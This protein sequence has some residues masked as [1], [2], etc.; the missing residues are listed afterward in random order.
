MAD[1]VTFGETM[2]RLS[3]PDHRRLEQTNLLDVNIGGAEWNVAVDLSRLGISTAWVSRLTDNALGWMIRNKAREQGVDISHIAWTKDDRIGIYFVEFGATP[4]PSSV[5]YDR[6]HS[7]ISQVKPGEINW[8]EVLK[9]AKW[10]H[11]S[12]I[13]PA[14][15][16]GA[17]Q[18]TTEALQIA[19]KAGCKVSYDLNYRGRLWTE[20]EA[21]KCQEPLMEHVDVL[22]STEE[23]TRKVLGIT[24]KDYREVAQK[25][26][27]NFNFEVVC[28]TLREDVSVLRNRWTAIAYSAG[29]IY[30]DRTYDVEIVDR[31][32]AGDS[33]T[34]GFIY[35]YLT[36][37]VAKGV[38][39]GNAYSA[40]KHSTPGD[41]NWATLKEVENLLK[42]GGLR[43]SR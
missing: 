39:Y 12:G 17:A 37:D 15:S 4:R 25:L 35:G 9:G 29:K 5:L 31:I 23:D 38:K 41:A 40:L 14:L 7:A 24:G 22:F 27:E 11:T 42:G 43:I 21:R 6:A 33:Y 26:A 34:A 30:D 3:P 18:V 2:V 20:E 36:G 28:I 13:T 16:P 32:G 8:E 1:V 10:F 19:K